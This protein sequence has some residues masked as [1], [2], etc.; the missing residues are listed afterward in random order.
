LK[1]A[2]VPGLA[3]R[4]AFIV[5]DFYALT[6][7]RRDEQRCGARCPQAALRKA[8]NIRSKTR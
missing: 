8:V 3:E 2:A 7:T 1:F 5:L 4:C 6:V